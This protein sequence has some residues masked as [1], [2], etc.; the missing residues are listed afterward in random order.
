MFVI[1]GTSSTKNKGKTKFLLYVLG[2]NIKNVDFY[3]NSD[4][5]TG[6]FNENSIL[7]Y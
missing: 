6:Y 5:Q 1:F 4:N 3:K 7:L 2:E